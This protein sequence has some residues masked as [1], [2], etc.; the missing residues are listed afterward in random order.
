MCK[1]AIKRVPA[2]WT[3]ASHGIRTPYQVDPE[4]FM[5]HLKF[6]DRDALR[7]TADHRRSMV[8]ADGRAAGSSWAKGGD[9]MVQVLDRSVAGVDPDDVPEF[10]PASVDLAGLVYRDDKD[11]YRT[12]KVGQIRAMD[13]QPLVRIPERLWGLV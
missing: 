8:E 6:Y 11:G 13:S 12:M 10:D 2:E 9:A 1:P 5:I 4:L 3:A 7:R